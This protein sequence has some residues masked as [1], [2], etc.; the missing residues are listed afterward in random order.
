MRLWSIFKIEFFDLL[1]ASFKTNKLLY[2]GAVR[3]LA[4]FERLATTQRALTS[5]LLC[6]LHRNRNR[7]YVS[8]F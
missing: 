5:A 3:E 6:C 2:A 8:R 7:T 1:E 4:S